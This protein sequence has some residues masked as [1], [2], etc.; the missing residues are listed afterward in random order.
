[1]GVLFA[2]DYVGILVH[3]LFYHLRVGGG[4]GDRVNDCDDSVYESVIL[5]FDII[6]LG[7]FNI[8]LWLSG[9]RALRHFMIPQSLNPK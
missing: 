9:T 4:G 3:T 6:G 1:M 7:F 5:G 2:P 8:F